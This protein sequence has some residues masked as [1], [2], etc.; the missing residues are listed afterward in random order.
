MLGV[1]GNLMG[2]WEIKKNLVSTWV[3]CITPVRPDLNYG[4]KLRDFTRFS[5]SK[6]DK[7]FFSYLSTLLCSR[8]Q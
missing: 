6:T 7:M 8:S 5:N 4:F 1:E 3:I 2:S